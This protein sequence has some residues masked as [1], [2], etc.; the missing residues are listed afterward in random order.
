MSDMTPPPSGKASRRWLGPAFLASL[1]LNLFLVALIAVAFVRGPADL[2]TFTVLAHC[3]RHTLA[4]FRR[5]LRK[6]LHHRI[7]PE[8]MQ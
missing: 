7:A 2:H 3:L 6:H 4:L 8:W 1:A 5:Q